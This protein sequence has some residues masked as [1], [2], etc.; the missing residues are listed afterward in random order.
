MSSL[1]EIQRDFFS[2]VLLPLRGQSRQQTDLVQS[3]AGHS[4]LFFAIAEKQIKASA[5]LI[6][7]ECLELYHRQYWFRILDSIEEDFPDLLR[8]LGK[9]EFWQ[10]V[11]EYL[12][13]RPSKSY[14]LR[15]LGEALPAFLATNLEDG[16]YRDR[17]VAVAEIEYGS[18]RAFE[19]ADPERASPE[20]VASGSFTL[21]PAIFLYTQRAN[22]SAW[23]NFG[24]DWQEGVF[25]T[26]VWR[27]RSGELLHRAL[28]PGEYSMLNRL[29]G[30]VYE[31]DLWL[32]DS[33]HDVEST[34]QLSEWFASWS[35]AE[36][37]ALPSSQTE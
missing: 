11:E 10:Q 29:K 31:L 23:I 1:S 25:Y 21:H 32:S 17:A 13:A 26:A 36:W 24:D 30:N 33:V 12:I 37:F 18:M 22:A 20:D 6:P 15:H 8:L 4:E 35:Q 19:A 28:H 3:D 7:A 27:S 34:D 5:N 9:K 14:T 2:A 16:I